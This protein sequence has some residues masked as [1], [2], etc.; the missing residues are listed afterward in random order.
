[1]GTAKNM[2]DHI[3]EL[4]TEVYRLNPKAE[5]H[6]H[7]VR[8]SLMREDGIPL[9]ERR[10]PVAFGVKVSRRLESL[11]AYKILEKHDKGHRNVTYSLSD[12]WKLKILKE[13]GLYSYGATLVL[14]NSP[15]DTYEQFKKKALKAIMKDMEEMM[16]PQFRKEYEEMKKKWGN[17][18]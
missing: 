6:W 8:N 2:D 11:A 14:E 10:K 5:L 1:M 16:E 7:E 13:K 18:Q 4:F 12:D 17:E 9:E 15:G 3:I